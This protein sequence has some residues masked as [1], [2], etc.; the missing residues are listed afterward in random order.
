[1]QHQQPQCSRLQLCVLNP[2]SVSNKSEQQKSSCEPS[3]TNCFQV[4]LL[5]ARSICNKTIDL[6]DFIKDSSAEVY[7]I[8]ETWLHGDARDDVILRELLPPG[9]KVDHSPRMSRGGGVAIVHMDS[10]S[11]THHINMK[12]ESFE[13]IEG[14]INTKPQLRFVLIYKPPPSAVRS[15]Y[16]SELSLRNSNNSWR[17]CS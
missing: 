17:S 16:P 10:L 14:Q 5:N 6:F 11:L 1:M 4:H 15:V 9:Y 8:T 7:A 12:F 2:W 3:P 13:Y